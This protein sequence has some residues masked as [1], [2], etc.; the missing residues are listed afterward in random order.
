MRV[1]NRYGR[2]GIMEFRDASLR[3]G[4]PLVMEIRYAEGDTVFDVQIQKIVD[5]N[6]DAILLWGNAKETGMIINAIREKGITLPIFGSDRLMSPELLEIAGKNAEGLVT[7]CQYNPTL[8][9]PKLKAFQK[10]YRDRFGL[11]P[12]V[13]AAHA[14]DGMNIIIEAIRIAGLNRYRIRDVL[15]DRKTFQH[16]AGVTGKLEIDP[17]WNDISPI[18]MTEIRNGK[19]VFFPSPLDTLNINK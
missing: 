2:V 12:D 9:N 5:S 6:P 4:H 16:Y 13:F 1:D 18:W 3:M 7:T 19:F 14:Y 17:S 15:L 11:E 8:D 10:N